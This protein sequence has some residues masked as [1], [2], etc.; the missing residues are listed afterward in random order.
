[1]SDYLQQFKSCG[2]NVTLAPGVF[3]EHPEAIEVGDNVTFMRGLVWQG[4]PGH[5]RIG[6]DVTFYPNCFIQGSP[7]RFEVGDHV[8]F[9]PG[10]YLSLGDWA[11]SFMDIGHH[12][13]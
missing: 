4:K 13:Q 6:S 10:N 12:S 3:I 7:G 2:S 5:C 1:M 9:F 11:A 8:G